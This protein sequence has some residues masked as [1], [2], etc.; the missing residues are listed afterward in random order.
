[1][2]VARFRDPTLR[3]FGAA[4]VLGGYEADKRHRARGGRKPA[5][6]AEFG[7]DGERRQVVDAAEAT[8]SLNARAERFEI[9]QGPQVLLD[10]PQAGD[11]FLDRAQ[12]GAM[13]VIERGERPRLRPQPDL[14]AF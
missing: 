11:R 1:M 8:Q 9:E 3:A 2:A 10:G 13:R 14:V 4:R 5:R 6:V 7:G 12:V